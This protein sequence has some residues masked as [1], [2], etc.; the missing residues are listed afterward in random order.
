MKK[1]F[2]AFVIV[3]SFVTSFAAC[4]KK[5]TTTPAKTPAMEQKND[6]TGGASYGGRKQA[7]ESKDPKDAAP[8]PK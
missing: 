6:A 1:T 7:P 5:D 2:V 8:S 3:S 4:S